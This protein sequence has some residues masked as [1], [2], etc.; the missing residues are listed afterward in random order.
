MSKILCIIDGMTDSGFCVAEYSHLSSMEPL[1]PVDTAQGERPESLRCILRLLGVEEI[2]SH[3]RGYAEALGNGIAVES[4][5]LV[6]RGSWF[7]RDAEGRCT[8]PVA[9]PESIRSDD[10][11]Y[12]ALGQYKS[13]LIFPHLAAEVEKLVTYPPYACSGQTAQALR[14]SGCAAV[15]AVFDENLSAARCLIPWGESTSATLPRF[16]QKAAVI[17]GT[18]IVCGIARL[19]GMALVEVAGAT[20]DVDTDLEAKVRAALQAAEEYP[21]VLLHI[22]GA[23]EAAHRCNEGEK[24]AFLRKVDE[25]VLSALLDSDHEIVVA[26]DHGTDPLSGQHLGGLQ[27]RFTRGKTVKYACTVQEHRKNLAV[28]QLR[29]K[30]K[31]LGRLPHKADF[32]ET[33]RIRIKAALGPWPRALEAAGLKERKPKQHR[34]GSAEK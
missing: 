15:E 27:P 16:P 7:A 8:V 22:N 9:A 24:R 34:Q 20:G 12:Y 14:P 17:C 29:R 30:A 3:L 25:E 32:P 6:L 10:C 11:R 21:F 31:E 1:P 23:D 13:L 4:D 26:A 18:A 28:E 33:D 19:L 2:P 5:D